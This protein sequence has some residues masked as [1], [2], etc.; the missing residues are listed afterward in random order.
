[1]FALSALIESEILG[2]RSK[3]L[4]SVSI[5]LTLVVGT[6]AECLVI[7][8]LRMEI[9]FNESSKHDVYSR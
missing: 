5:P 1:M 3:I 6:G 2:D 7:Y 4:Q 9:I 8:Q